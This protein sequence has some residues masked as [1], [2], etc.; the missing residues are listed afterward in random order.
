MLPHE[1]R[2]SERRMSEK[3]A[4]MIEARER[5]RIKFQG[6]NCEINN[7]KEVK[8]LK[9]YLQNQKAIFDSLARQKIKR[10]KT[11]AI[12]KY[13]ITCVLSARLE[14]LIYS[15]KILSLFCLFISICCFACLLIILV[16]PASLLCEE[17]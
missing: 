13:S 17:R 16:S 15:E 7:Y 6:T 10:G 2:E 9:N 8:N 11:L 5:A 1:S 4:K 12:S 3:I 14:I